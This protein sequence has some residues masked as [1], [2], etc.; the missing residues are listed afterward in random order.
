VRKIEMKCWGCNTKLKAEGPDGSLLVSQIAVE[1][2]K[3]HVHHNPGNL[4]ITETED[5]EVLTGV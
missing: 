3:A 2:A 1:F 5:T 4:T